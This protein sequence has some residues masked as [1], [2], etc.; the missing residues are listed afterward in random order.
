MNKLFDGKVL[1]MEALVVTAVRDVVVF[2]D[3]IGIAQTGGLV[4]E[5]IS[6]DTVGV[7]EFPANTTDT[8]AVGTVVYWDAADGNI[9]TDSDSGTNMK[10]GIS[11]SIK[12]GGTE[13]SVEV[14]IG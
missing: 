14:K 7:Y 11:W 1:L 2:A 8:F 6:V 3:S 5:K 9:T 12:A 10:A 13:G 4:G